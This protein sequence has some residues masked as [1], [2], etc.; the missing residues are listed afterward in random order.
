MVIYGATHHPFA[1]GLKNG[2]AEKV[3][4]A[5]I[6]DIGSSVQNIS[7]LEDSV[8]SMDGAGFTSPYFSRQQ[9]FS[10]IDAKV[11]RNKKTIFADINGQYG[12]PKLLKWAEYEITNS[13]RRLS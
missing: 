1:Q 8:D 10:L 11:G 3:K 4:M 7:G 6:A 9:N 12:L 2:V 13:V 5:V